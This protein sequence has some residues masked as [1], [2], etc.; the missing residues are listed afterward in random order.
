M[1][2]VFRCDTKTDVKEFFFKSF[3]LYNKHF[4]LYLQNYLQV[5]PIAHV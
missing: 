4:V 5:L 3:K 1:P 2:W